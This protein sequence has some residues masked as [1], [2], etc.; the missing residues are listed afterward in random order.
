MTRTL[1]DFRAKFRL[2]E[3]TIA[4]TEHWTW[5]VRPAQTTLGAT[6]LSMNRLCP[7]F[8]EMTKSEARDLGDAARLVESHVR[9]LWAPER[10]NYL[11]FMLVD[12]HVHFHVLPRYAGPRSF[13]GVAWTDPAWPKPLDVMAGSPTFDDRVLFAARDYLAR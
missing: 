9:H 8:G 11:M 12:E 5:S 13:A 3:L 7:A 6:V 4:V 10:F 2:N 1:S